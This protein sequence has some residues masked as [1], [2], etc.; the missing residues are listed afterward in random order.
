[1]AVADLDEMKG[2]FRG[3]HFLAKCPGCQHAG[4]DAPYHAGPSPGHALEEPA[5]IDAVVVVIVND[6]LRQFLTSK[7]LRTLVENA[8]RNAKPEMQTIYSNTDLDFYRGA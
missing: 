2:A 5:T 8:L 6:Y 7:N 1:M 4:A 3:C